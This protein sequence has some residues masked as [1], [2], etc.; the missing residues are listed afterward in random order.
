MWIKACLNGPR[1][2]A[3]HPAL[4]ITPA[5][6][7]REARAAVAAGAVAL[8][9]HPRA[10][11][12]SET[13]DAGPVD[14]ALLAVR[15]AC[16]GIPIELSTAAWIVGDP[17][18]RLA[19]VRAWQVLPDSAAVNF[20]EAGAETLVK[21]LLEMGLEVEA[22]LFNAADAGR[23]VAS[24]LARHCAHLQIEPILDATPAAALLTAQAIA[25]VLDQSGA[26]TPRLLHG[27]DASAWP[28]LRAALAQ[29]YAT[30]IGLE[31]TLLLPDGATAA[32]NAA[33]LRAAWEAASA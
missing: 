6:L 21:T 11:D 24:G 33:L 5:E 23:L 4:P 32:D 27:K 31:D 13:L 9:F 10:A 30:R 15:A 20:G 2:R 26:A 17:D 22:G 18:R 14:E 7:A 16:P 19:R 3:S 8:H 25:R 28:L 1:P 12:G 29:G